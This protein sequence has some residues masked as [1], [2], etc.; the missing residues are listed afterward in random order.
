MRWIF[1]FAV[2]LLPLPGHTADEAMLL[3]EA[4]LS[5]R[6]EK[7]A[8]DYQ[9]LDARNREAQRLAAIPFATRYQINTPLKRGLVL[10]VADDDAAAV[11]VAKGIPAGNGRAVFAIKGGAEAWRRVAQKASAPTSVSGSFVIPMNTCEQGKPLQQLRRD[12]PLPQ[13]QKK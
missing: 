11:A 2:L 9:L 12:K 7:A 5:V 1:C 6:L 4:A 10:V 3:D 8:E 13:F